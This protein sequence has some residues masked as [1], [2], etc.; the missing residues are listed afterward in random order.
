MGVNA[1]GR[2]E[3]LGLQVGDSE[4]EGFWKAMIGSLKERGLAGGKLVVSDAHVGLTKAIRC[5]FQ[6]CCWQRC[7]RSSPLRGR[8]PPT[9][10]TRCSGYPRPTR[11]WSRLPCAR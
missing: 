5:M 7:R 3:L 6:G 2:R 10:G 8:L 1:D 9:P 11:A 4:S